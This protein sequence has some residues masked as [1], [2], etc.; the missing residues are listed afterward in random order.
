LGEGI[1]RVDLLRPERIDL[2][3]GVSERGSG[4]ISS[5]LRLLAEKDL[6]WSTLVFEQN[7]SRLSDT[8]LALEKRLANR[9]FLRT[10]WAR[11]QVGRNLETGGAWGL[12]F[13]VRWELD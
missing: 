2:V 5:E 8:W 7:L 6:G 12:E 4:T 9:L 3:S 11:E 10:T 13:N 1:A